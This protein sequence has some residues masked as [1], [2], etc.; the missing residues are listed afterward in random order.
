MDCVAMQIFIQSPNFFEFLREFW[1]PK[2][3]PSRLHL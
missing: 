3:A 1:L 2:L